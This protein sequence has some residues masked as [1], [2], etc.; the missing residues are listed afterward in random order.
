MW[1]FNV[2]KMMSML[3]RLAY[4]N[5]PCGHSSYTLAVLG[6]PWKHPSRKKWEEA[7]RLLA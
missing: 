5:L 4:L 1:L 6:S 3:L 7:G 2:P